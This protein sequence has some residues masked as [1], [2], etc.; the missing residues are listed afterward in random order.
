MKTWEGIREIVTIYR[1]G[2]IDITS[3][4][5]AKKLSANEVN[6][7]LT[8]ISKQRDEKLVIAKHKYYKHLTNPNTNFSF[9]FPTSS[10]NVLKCYR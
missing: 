2:K 6:K 10:H 1:K 9:K 3:I 5:I 4:Q 8:S 7:H